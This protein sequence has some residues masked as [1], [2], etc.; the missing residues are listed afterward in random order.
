MTV[1]DNTPIEATVPS[2]DPVSLSSDNKGTSDEYNRQRRTVEMNVYY[3]KKYASYLDILMYFTFYCI[4]LLILAILRKRM[5]IS[6]SFTNILTMILVIIGGMHLYLKIADINMRDNMDFD[7][8]DWGF[9]PD[10]HSD[11]NQLDTNLHEISNNEGASCVEEACC[12]LD[13]TKWCASKGKCV[14]KNALCIGEENS[15]WIGVRGWDTSTSD[16]PSTADM[17]ASQAGASAE[18]DDKDSDDCIKNGE[19]NHHALSQ[20]NMPLNAEQFVSGISNTFSSF[21]KSFSREA[22][23][24][25]P[26]T[27]K[28][29]SQL[30]NQYSPV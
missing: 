29:F 9:N 24:K 7:E 23:Y 28:A 26:S 25:I 15:P 22:Q 18:C 8:Y 30:D 13:T 17:Q 21:K 3:E 2:E 11:P 27:V 19:G 6:Y 20:H 10:N 14:L 5:I 1:T 12:T 4:V 16:G